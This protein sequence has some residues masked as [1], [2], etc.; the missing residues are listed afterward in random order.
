MDRAIVIQVPPEWMKDIPEEDLTLRQIFKLGLTQ[1]KVQRALALYREG[2]GSLGYLAET[3]GLPKRQ[4]IIA[5]R[6]Q[7]I[8]PDYAEETIREELA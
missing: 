8:E 2:A 4:L 5:A 1:Y 6:Q 3:L 7:G